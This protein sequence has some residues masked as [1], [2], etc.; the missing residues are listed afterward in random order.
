LDLIYTI[1]VTVFTLAILVTV[2]EF[3]HF[4]VARRCGVKVLRFS[5]G[6]G[7]PLL[8]W[9]D[10][11]DTEYVI[12]AFPL[13]G[14]V[15]MLD[16]RADEVTPDMEEY[17]FNRK[18]VLQRIAVVAAGPA[19]NLLL[20]V[21][22]YWFVFMAGESGV[23]PVI[24]SVEEGSIAELAGLEAGQEIVAIDGHDTPT[25][26]AVNF[27]LLDRIGDSGPLDFAVRYPDSDFIYQSQGVLDGW[28]SNQDSPDLIAGLG[29]EMHRP[30][31]EVVLDE[32]VEGSPAAAAGLAG[33]D[34][35]LSADGV[36]MSEW[37]DWV[38]YV[39]ARPG[40]AIEI[41]YDRAGGSA[42]TVIVPARK[43]DAAGE[44][45]GQVGV[46][47]RIPEW[48]EHM[49]REF[50]Y[51]PVEALFLAGQRT[52][53][54]VVF[55]LGAIKKMLT[56]LISPKNLSGPITIAKVAT[57]SAESGLESFVAFLALLSVSLGVLNLLPIPV[58]DGG[59]LMYYT[60]EFFVGRPVPLKVQ[61]LG[62][63]VGLFIIIGVMMLA[64]YN[65]FARL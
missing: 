37:S 19:A 57:A 32:V 28:L 56:G 14:Y 50:H 33:G 55:T 43:V 18:P 6:F 60:I 36:P 25:W 22:A 4:W 10:K 8:R 61:M 23:A 46:S 52:G 40:Q 35:I 41:A 30:A 12:A 2:H 34:R 44:P 65:D 54:L 53:D 20:A 64:L 38:S 16:E 24:G 9:R 13:G 59:H 58:L 29:I 31:I 63:Q 3:G 42:E 47:V 62:Y 51:G 21:L 45:F 7:T 48:P 17:A 11:Q 49:L 26:Q 39:R 27:R 5:I 1:L 15:K